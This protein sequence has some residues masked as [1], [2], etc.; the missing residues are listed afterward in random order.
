MKLLYYILLINMLYIIT[1]CKSDYVSIKDIEGKWISK[2]GGVLYFQNNNKFIGENLPTEVFYL[3][4]DT[5]EE[6]INGSGV[7]ELQEDRM[8]STGYSTII[9][10]FNNTTLNTSK[11][12]LELM[13][14]GSGFFS[15]KK[16]WKKIFLSVGD[17]DSGNTYSFSK[18]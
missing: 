15:N 5:S 10:S 17:P 16:P 11:F 12:Q 6:K 4:G 9:V 14:E 2:D 18:E 13:I 3:W 7:W 8:K 1:G